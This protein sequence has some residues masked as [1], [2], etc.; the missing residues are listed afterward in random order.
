MDKRP[1]YIGLFLILGI[2][3]ALALSLYYSNAKQVNTKAG[4]C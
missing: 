2:I 1:I 3:I 4:E